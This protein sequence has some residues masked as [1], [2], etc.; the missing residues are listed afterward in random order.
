MKDFA[1]GIAFLF[2]VAAA[3]YYAGPL[4]LVIAAIVFFLIG[5]TKF[6]ERF[7]RTA[8]AIFGFLSGLLGGGRRW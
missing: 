3:W 5:V 4:L 6:S 8:L 2:V 7:P 1:I